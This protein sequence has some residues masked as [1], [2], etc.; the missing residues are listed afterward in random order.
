MN[1]D[2]LRSFTVSEIVNQLPR[3]IPVFEKLNID[4][5]CNAKLPFSEAC[6]NAN[7]SEEEV[8]SAL[9]GAS[10]SSS[11]I[12]PQDW[13]LDL[14]TSYIVQNH[15]QY[16]KRALLEIHS[17]INRVCAKH[18]THHPELEEIRQQ[19]MTLSQDLQTHMHN[20]EHVLFPSVD[21]LVKESTRLLPATEYS[22][23]SMSNLTPVIVTMETEHELAGHCLHRIRA[24][25]QNFAL[26]SDACPSYIMLFGRLQEF[27]ADLHVHIHLE[28]NLLFPKTLALQ[29]RQQNKPIYVN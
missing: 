23:K 27:E 26:P 2:T 5:C 12:R 1:T 10:A 20:E 4:Y 8:L 19:F 28:N 22:I 9:K 3:A 29:A 15:H 14:L 7:I 17:L 21:A 13:S 11:T 25:S 18:G 16:A 24:V 6:Q